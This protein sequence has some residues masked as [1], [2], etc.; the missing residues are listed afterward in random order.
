MTKSRETFFL[1]SILI[2]MLLLGI[3][4]VFPVKETCA[5]GEFT[6]NC[7]NITAFPVQLGKDSYGIAMIDNI[8]EHIWI[9]EINRSGNRLKLLAAR[10]WQYDRSLDQFNT[11]DPTPEQVRKLLEKFTAP[12][13]EQK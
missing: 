4:G 12:A 3:K 9:Y 13:T 5:T 10:S 6:N 1:A 8:S 11:S 7:N 2:L